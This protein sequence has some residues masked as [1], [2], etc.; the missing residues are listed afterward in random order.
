MK[1]WNAF[2]HILLP[3][4]CP[5]CKQ[6]LLN[7]E[8]CLCQHCYL[9]LPSTNMPLKDN[10]VTD[11]FIG[12]VPIVQGHAAYYMEKDNIIE[13]LLYLI[14]YKDQK[15]LAHKLGTIWAKEL[16]QKNIQIDSVLPIPLSQKKAYKRGYNQAYLLANCISEQLKVPILEPIS[17]IKN[18]QSQTKKTRLE[19]LQNMEDAFLLKKK[20]KLS[21][22]HPFIIDDVITTGA[23]I[24]T[25]CTALLKAYP[26]INISVGALATK[27]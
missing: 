23:T 1:I 7:E 16:R 10:L 14:K 18:T 11:K 9:L 8:E 12:R 5:N 17:R 25:Y 15:Q 2:T 13:H 6:P 4:V 20:Y 21:V 3:D 27:A 24:E 26:N 22:S 19:R